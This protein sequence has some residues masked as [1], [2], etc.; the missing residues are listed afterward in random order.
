MSKDEAAVEAEI[1][2]KGLTA[3][4]LTPDDIEQTI[5]GEYAFTLDKATEGAPQLPGMASFTIVALVLRNGFI[6]TGESA[7]ASPANF[8]AALGHKIARE[9]AKKKIWQLE[10]YLL[11]TRLADAPPQA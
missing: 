11:R 7:P 3:P 1:Q 10:G 6:V 2:A 4:R 9:N 8:D 5:V